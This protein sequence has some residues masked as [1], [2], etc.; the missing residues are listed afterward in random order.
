MAE[1]V[2]SA[3]KEEKPVEAA[4]SF[5]RELFEFQITREFRRGTHLIYDCARKR[6]LCVNEDGRNLCRSRRDEDIED[7]F[8]FLRCAV[9]KS[10]E[11][12]DECVENQYRMIHSSID[13]RFCLNHQIER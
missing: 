7:Q 13:K 5:T 11:T 12:Y 4:G 2:S 10:Y 1:E 8:Y 9:M 6:F 3:K